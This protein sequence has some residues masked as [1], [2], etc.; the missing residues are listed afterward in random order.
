M[1][2]VRNMRTPQRKSSRCERRLLCSQV[3]ACADRVKPDELT[4]ANAVTFTG[5]TNVITFG[6]A[7][8]GLTGN[9]ELQGAATV[10]M[11]AAAGVTTVRNVITGTGSLIQSGANALSLAGANTYTG[12][13][14]VTGGTLNIGATGSI[15]SNVT[16]QTAFN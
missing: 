10:Q 13:T 4:R 14:T 11:N 3:G 1:S 12:A 8:S 5:G 7:T 6:A 9:G 16:V 15:T 2:C